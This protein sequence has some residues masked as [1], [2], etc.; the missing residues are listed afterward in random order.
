MLQKVLDTTTIGN[1]DTP[2]QGGLTYAQSERFLDYMFDN[3]VLLNLVTSKRMRAVEEEWSVV[4]LGRRIIRPAVEAVDTGENVGPTFSRVSITTK[5]IRVDWE[6]ST[7]SLEDN[8][9]GE[10]L[11][12]HIARMIATQVGNDMEDLAINGDTTSNEVSLSIFDGWRKLG[13]ENG[14]VVSNNG[15]YLD[16]RA[17]HRAY[18][19]VPRD[20][21]AN[22]GGLR[23]FAGGSMI[24]DYLFSYQEVEQGLI[25][26]EATAAAALGRETAATGAAGWTP[27]SPF[28]I[29]LTEVPLF[30]EQLD[31]GYDT[32]SGTSGVQVPNANIDHGELWLVDPKN[33]IFG[34]KRDIR[35][36]REYVAKKDTI[37]YTIYMRAGVGVQRDVAFTILTDVRLRD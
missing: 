32:D 15:E 33:L 1:G 16:R 30:N 20:V 13:L 36:H 34:V 29:S 2:G 7:E 24:S 27:A 5:K 31:G 3:R 35:I 14:N 10:E 9:E 22:R 23:F 19:A 21:R 37:E 6:L 17:F 26:P 18:R 11:E 4:A 25:S 28:G 8:I 12:D